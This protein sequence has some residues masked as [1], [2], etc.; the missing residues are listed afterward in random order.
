MK[1]YKI[2]LKDAKELQ[3][4]AENNPDCN[5]LGLGYNY[6]AG[7]IYT[8]MQIILSGKFHNR[9]V[10]DGFSIFLLDEIAT[11]EEQ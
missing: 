9:A 4:A 1:R 2:I 7:R 6:Y 5:N 10:T 11:M 3:Q 8:N